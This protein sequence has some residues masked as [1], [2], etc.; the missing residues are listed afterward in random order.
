MFCLWKGAFCNTSM[1]GSFKAKLS[2]IVLSFSV[3]WFMQ[4]VASNCRRYVTHYMVPLNGVLTWTDPDPTAGRVTLSVT[5]FSVSTNCTV[6]STIFFFN[7]VAFSLTSQLYFYVAIESSTAGIVVDIVCSILETDFS[8]IDN[9]T[10]R[11][12][13]IRDS[14][15]TLYIYSII[16]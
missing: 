16:F 1:M 3:Q 4:A 8:T 11:Q 15:N 13:C 6:C 14:I 2:K 9:L 5:L 10:C 7:T 12:M